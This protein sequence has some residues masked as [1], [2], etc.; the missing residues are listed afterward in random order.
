M[1][2]SASHVGSL[3]SACDLRLAM[4]NHLQKALLGR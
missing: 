3:S 2:Q 1:V 4:M